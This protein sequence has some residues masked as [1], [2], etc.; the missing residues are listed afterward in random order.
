MLFCYL[1]VVC[2][3]CNK[4]NQIFYV[5][6][7]ACFKKEVQRN[8]KTDNIL[9][10]KE[11]LGFSGLHKNNFVPA[12]LSPLWNHAFHRQS[13][14]N[15]TVLV[16]TTVIQFWTRFYPPKYEAFNALL[17]KHVYIILCLYLFFDFFLSASVV[18]LLSQKQALE[19]LKQTLQL[20]RCTEAKLAAQKELLDKK[21]QE[22]D[23]KEPPPVVNYEEDDVRSVASVV[24]AFLKAFKTPCFTHRAVRRFG[25]CMCPPVDAHGLCMPIVLYHLQYKHT[26]KSSG[27]FIF[28]MAWLLKNVVIKHQCILF[29][30]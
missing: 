23:G 9:N 20:L 22:N 25:K 4:V 28:W 3:Y 1:V 7:L 24:R 30:H 2:C 6:D 16:W 21:M 26:E 29:Q 8:D 5:W 12:P 15:E 17:S 13:I 18:L 27:L 14:S 19:E 10:S 11:I